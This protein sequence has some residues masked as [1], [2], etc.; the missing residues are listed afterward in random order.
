[1]VLQGHATLYLRAHLWNLGGAAVFRLLLNRA[2]FL[3]RVFIAVS[4]KV[5]NAW[6]K[7]RGGN[8]RFE[9]GRVLFL[10]IIHTVL[11]SQFSMGLNVFNSLTLT[12]NKALCAWASLRT[13]N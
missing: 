8:L 10:Y 4:K 9:F 13:V 2:V 7:S 1:M 3:S 6:G 12:C 5:K 11:R